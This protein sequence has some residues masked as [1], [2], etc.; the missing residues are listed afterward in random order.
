VFSVYVLVKSSSGL[1]KY[2]SQTHAVRAVVR[3]DLG[4]NHVWSVCV[5]G[6]AFPMSVWVRVKHMY[7]N[8]LGYVCVKV[9]CSRS[10]S[11][12]LSIV[13]SQTENTGSVCMDSTDREGYNNPCSGGTHVLNYC[14]KMLSFGPL[15]S[16]PGH[17]ALSSTASLL[18][19][20]T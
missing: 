15:Q 20:T 18:P 13:A 3:F 7:A 4:P 8:C 16:N 11:I 19:L 9:R 14:H 5:S 17:S 12:W 10:W 6:Q 1:S 2:T